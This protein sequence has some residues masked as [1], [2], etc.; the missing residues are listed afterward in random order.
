MRFRLTD[1][2]VSGL[3]GAFWA[4]VGFTILLVIAL[5]TMDPA[6]IK[7][8]ESWVNISTILIVLFLAGSSWSSGAYSFHLY[9]ETGFIQGLYPML[10]TPLIG[11]GWIVLSAF[12]LSPWIRDWAG[13]PPKEFAGGGSALEV[14]IIGGAG[15]LFFSAIG[16]WQ[17]REEAT[18]ASIGPGHASPELGNDNPPEP[19]PIRDRPVVDG[20]RDGEFLISNERVEVSAGAYFFR[21]KIFTSKEQLEAYLG[22]KI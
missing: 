6:D 14:F 5:A 18:N 12:V 4:L 17:A 20:E 11:G 8:Q 13:F 9:A 3:G 7:V 16:A 21:G 2:F 10:L 22:E 1:Y 19:T 15:A